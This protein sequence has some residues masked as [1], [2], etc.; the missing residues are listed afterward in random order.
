MKP[1]QKPA[2][3]PTKKPPKNDI[4][5]GE[6]ESSGEFDASGLDAEESSGSQLY[7]SNTTMNLVTTEKSVIETSSKSDSDQSGVECPPKV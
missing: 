5:S 6:S 3:K 4:F 1:T 2:R 7:F